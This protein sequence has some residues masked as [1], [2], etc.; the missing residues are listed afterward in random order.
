LLFAR[1][2]RDSAGPAYVFYLLLLL[3]FAFCKILPL[4][5]TF[6]KI[7]PF[8]RGCTAFCYFKKRVKTTFF[9]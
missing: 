8:I 6:S 2:C 7:R 5:V 1:F 9:I 3:F 4:V